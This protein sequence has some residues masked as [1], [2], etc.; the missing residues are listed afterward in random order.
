MER[1]LQ[2]DAKRL[3]PEGRQQRTSGRLIVNAALRTARQADQP[4]GVLGEVGDCQH[5]REQTPP[6]R[7]FARVRVRPRE[8]PAEVA[9]AEPIA[10]QQGDVPRPARRLIGIT[11][12]HSLALRACRRRIGQVHLRPMDRAQAERRRGLGEL[13]RSRDGVVVGQRQR[14]V[15]ALQRGYDQLLGQRGAVQE[16]EGRMA[17]ELDV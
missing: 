6:A 15:P 3:T 10:N 16:R 13:H 1:T 5:R 11:Q 14:L 2:L 7:R 8:E 17:V 9:P 12:R 4:L